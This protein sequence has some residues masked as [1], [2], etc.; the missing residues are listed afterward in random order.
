MIGYLRGKLLDA[1]PETIL[2]DVGGVGYELAIP[3]STY[4]EIDR[5]DRA[6]AIGL[7]VHTHVRADAIGDD[8]WSARVS[9]T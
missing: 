5:S 2:L 4:A 8:E 3:L 1:G 6:Q 9:S 7:Y